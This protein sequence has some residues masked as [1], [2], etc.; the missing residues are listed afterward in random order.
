MKYEFTVIVDLES[1]LHQP[2]PEID[3]YVKQLRSGIKQALRDHIEEAV[4]AWGGQLWPGHIMFSQNFKRV[5]ARSRRRV[6]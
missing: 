2:H 1:D 5:T 3:E 6:A 4:G